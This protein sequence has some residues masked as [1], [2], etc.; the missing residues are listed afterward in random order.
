MR[1]SKF[2]KPELKYLTKSIDDDIAQK[3]EFLK[4][5]L[6]W[7]EEN[8]PT[9]PYYQRDVDATF[10]KIHFLAQLRMKILNFA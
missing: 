1:S 7:M 6:K 8:K 4:H 9:D 3:N 5:R 2:L 10:K